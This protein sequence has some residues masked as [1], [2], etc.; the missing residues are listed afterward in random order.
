M[1]GSSFRAALRVT[2]AGCSDRPSAPVTP[3]EAGRSP[4]HQPGKRL[5]MAAI[6]RRPNTSKPARCH[7]VYPYLLRKL[8]IMRP[9]STCSAG[10]SSHGGSITM[11]SAFCI[12]AVE[13]ALAKHGEPV[14]RLHAKVG[15]KHP[16]TAN[17][18]IEFVGTLWRAASATHNR[19]WQIRL[20]GSRRSRRPNGSGS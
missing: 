18:V 19:Q 13:E 12:E 15:K 8:P 5:G 11:D 10:R 9:W 17:R 4:R 7:K 3:E 20:P 16:S 1:K 6:Y 2:P 14:A